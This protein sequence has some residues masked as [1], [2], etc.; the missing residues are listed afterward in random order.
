MQLQT[1]S[2]TAPVRP[3][4]N[5]APQYLFNEPALSGITMPFD[6]GAEIYGENEPAEY[7]YKVVSGS[8][9]TYSVLNDGRRHIGAFYLP[10]DIF[11]VE[12]G[13]EHSL[14]A[15]A[16]AD[17]TI[18]LVRRSTVMDV[19]KRNTNV[20]AQ[21]LHCTSRELHQARDHVQLLIKTA[22]ERVASFLL[23]MSGRLSG[24]TVALPMSRQD[25]A[26]YLGL[27]IETVSRTLTQLGLKKAIE[28]PSSRTIILRN[29][30]ALAR[31]NS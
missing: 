28:L 20:M 24:E 2:Q 11:G 27:T 10:G 19:A 16:I 15:E 17:A 23:E 5:A 9:R 18:L 26:D 21:L 22:Q 12:S 8:V 6:K 14:S 25:I 3:M 4:R 1:N 13:P 31:L 30:G 29:R 7:V